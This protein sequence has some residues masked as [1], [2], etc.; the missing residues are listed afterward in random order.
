M[1]IR[2]KKNKTGTISIQVIDKSSGKYKVIHSVGS[3]ADETMI[4]DLTA[5]AKHYINKIRK[6][7]FIFNKVN[8]IYYYI[9]GKNHGNFK[10]CFSYSNLW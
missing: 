8:S 4:A 6:N 3:S 10:R 7:K 9:G 1:F 5:Q 2:Q